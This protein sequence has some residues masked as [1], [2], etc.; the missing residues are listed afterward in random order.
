MSLIELFMLAAGL[1]TDAFAIAVCIG[2]ALQKTDWRKA[3]AVGLYFGCFQAVMPLLGYAGAIRFAGLI[4]MYSHWIAFGLLLFI[5]GKMIMGSLKPDGDKKYTPSLKPVHMLP[6]A[7]ATSIDALA[8]GVSFALLQESIVPMAALTGAV[9]FILSAAGVLIG[10]SL[11]VKMKRKAEFAGGLILI[12][13][14]IRILLEHFDVFPSEELLLITGS[15]APAC[16]I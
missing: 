4:V 8:V 1:S 2:L 5:G 9:T 3:A 13:I 10:K 14:G 11:G 16:F 12:M 15:F 7:L 6:F